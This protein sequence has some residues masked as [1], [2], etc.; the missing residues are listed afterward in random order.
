MKILILRF[1]SIGDIVLTTPVVRCL[2]KKYPD[3][4]MAYATKTA[5]EEVVEANP[6]VNKVY[7]FKS[8]VNEII[9]Q[10]KQEKF[11]V[12]IDLHKNIRSK[13]VRRTLGVT[14]YSFPKLNLQ[15]WM[16]VN[17]GINRLPALHIV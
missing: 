8:D 13:Q 15:K 14:S 5:F 3:A 16:L 12:I 1:S 10:L 2:R 17:F 7:S 6:Y 11:D 4:Y 9:P